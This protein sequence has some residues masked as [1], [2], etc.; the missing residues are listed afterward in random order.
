M[1][2]CEEIAICFIWQIW[3]S[4]IRKFFH[5]RL[6]YPTTL[7]RRLFFITPLEIIASVQGLHYNTYTT[8]ILDRKRKWENVWENWCSYPSWFRECIIPPSWIGIGHAQTAFSPQVRVRVPVVMI[9]AQTVAIQDPRRKAGRQEGSRCKHAS[10]LPV[11]QIND[12]NQEYIWQYMQQVW[13]ILKT[14]NKTHP[15]NNNQHR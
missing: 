6:Q 1:Q 5:E 8:V 2:A 10:A 14:A 9:L 7:L 4:I 11:W 3:N 13:C 12:T 15:L